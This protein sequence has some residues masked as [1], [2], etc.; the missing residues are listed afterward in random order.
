M[1]N[2]LRT[3]IFD[4]RLVPGVSVLPPAAIILPCSCHGNSVTD[5]V[6]LK[7]PNEAFHW[8]KSREIP[9]SVDEFRNP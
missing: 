4:G 1:L 7:I 3:E 5:G 8:E 2:H 6:D 9:E